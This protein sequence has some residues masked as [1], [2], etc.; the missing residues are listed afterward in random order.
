M[1]VVLGFL[2][3]CGENPVTSATSVLAPGRWMGPGPFGVCLSV[4]Q[5]RC[6]L[7]AGCGHGQFPPPVVAAD[8]TFA[9]DGTY[10]IEVGPL[11]LPPPQSPPARFSGVLAD[12]RLIL[13]VAPASQPPATYVL[14]PAGSGTC[15]VPCV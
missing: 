6:D 11:S 13:T 1:A 8:G 9:V 10:L 4:T 15:T 12:S 3:A 2:A 7:V 5:T 14:T